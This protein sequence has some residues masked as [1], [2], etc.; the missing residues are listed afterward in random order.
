MRAHRKGVR[1]TG[2]SSAAPRV[3]GE[4]SVEADALDQQHARTWVPRRKWF[5]VPKGPWP[6]EVCGDYLV[7]GS[8]ARSRVVRDERVYRH[9]DCTARE[10]DTSRNRVPPCGGAA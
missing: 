3:V 6:C 8:W 5:R 2:W 7:P 10:H 4:R 1:A 9:R